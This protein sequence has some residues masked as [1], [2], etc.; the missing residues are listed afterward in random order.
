VKVD[1]GYRFKPQDDPEHLLR[2]THAGKS[3][4]FVTEEFSLRKYFK[5]TIVVRGR[6]AG[7]WFTRIGVQ[8]QWLRPGE[9][10]S[11]TLIGP[12][13]APKPR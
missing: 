12:E 11:A 7:D 9:R 4:D 13:P 8:G 1:E 5:K 2:F 6:L 3:R 10:R